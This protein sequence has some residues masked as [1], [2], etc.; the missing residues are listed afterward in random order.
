MERVVEKE[1]R[2]IRDLV[3]G[4]LTRVDPVIR[5][6]LAKDRSERYQSAAD[7]VSALLPTK[8]VR[9]GL[10]VGAEVDGAAS[11]VVPLIAKGSVPKRLRR[12]PVDARREPLAPCYSA[13]HAHRRAVP[14]CCLGSRPS[15]SLE[16]CCCPTAG[17][18]GAR[19]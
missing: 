3:P 11:A 8:A 18:D 16:S 6:A 17:Y 1:P 19:T 15:R 13:S 12:A 10:L 2:P 4:C 5:K 9:L 7:F 14:G